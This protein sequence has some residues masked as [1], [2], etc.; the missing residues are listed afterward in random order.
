MYVHT[1]IFNKNFL[2]TILVYIPIAGMC[3]QWSAV[4]GSGQHRPP[5]RKKQPPLQTH[6]PV[7]KYQ[8]EMKI[9]RLNFQLLYIDIC[10]CV[11]M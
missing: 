8:H 5:L 10:M 7:L 3:P 11:C 6:W 1:Y 4:V 2:F 9:L